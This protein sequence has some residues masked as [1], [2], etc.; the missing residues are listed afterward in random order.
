MA[1]ERTVM[2]VLP[3]WILAALLL[4]LVLCL[5]ALRVSFLIFRRASER[6]GERNPLVEDV[7][8]PFIFESRV[9]EWHVQEGEKV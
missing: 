6:R 8:A 2:F 4:G 7:Y 5:H 9:E 1:A 3:N